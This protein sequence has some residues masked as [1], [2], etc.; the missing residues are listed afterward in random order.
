MRF[1]SK[2]AGSRHGDLRQKN[3][4]SLGAGFSVDFIYCDGE[5]LIQWTPDVPQ[6][7]QQRKIMDSY[8]RARNDFLAEVMKERGG[9]F[10]FLNPDLSLSVIDGGG[11][12]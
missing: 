8:I 4:V 7:Q 2:S 6:G 12:G 1:R 3:G 5:L 10:V 11:N 9:T